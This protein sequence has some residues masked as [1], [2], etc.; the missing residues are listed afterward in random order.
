[1]AGGTKEVRGFYHAVTPLEAVGAPHE[2]INPTFGKADFGA[3]H[4]SRIYTQPFATN[5]ILDLIHLIEFGFKTTKAYGGP[6]ICVCPCASTPFIKRSP[7]ILP[8][9]ASR[10]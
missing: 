3:F 6:T 1:M 8:E 9:I 10:E 4:V 7:K 2:E 5:P